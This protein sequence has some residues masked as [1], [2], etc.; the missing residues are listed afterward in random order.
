MSENARIVYIANC[1]EW[2]NQHGWEGQLE[3][4]VT[5]IMIAFGEDDDFKKHFKLE[6]TRGSN[7]ASMCGEVLDQIRDYCKKHNPPLRLLFC[8][9]NYD[10]LLKAKDGEQY[11]HR[12]IRQLVKTYSNYFF[13]ILATSRNQIIPDFI[14]MQLRVPTTFSKAE[15]VGVTKHFANPDIYTWIRES[16]HNRILFF[17]LVRRLTENNPREVILLLRHISHVDRKNNKYYADLLECA[18]E[19]QNSPI[20]IENENDNKDYV[21]CN[22]QNNTDELTTLTVNDQKLIT[23]CAFNRIYFNAASISNEKLKREPKLLFHPLITQ[24][25]LHGVD[26]NTHLLLRFN[27]PR[28]G[29]HAMKLVFGNQRNGIIEV[30]E[31]FG[32]GSQ[33]KYYM[34]YAGLNLLIKECELNKMNSNEFRFHST[35]MDMYMLNIKDMSGNQAIEEVAKSID[36]TISYSGIG[37]VAFYTFA[38]KDAEIGPFKG[39]DFALKYFRGENAMAYIICALYLSGSDVNNIID[40]IEKKFVNSDYI[41]TNKYCPVVDRILSGIDTIFKTHQELSG[42]NSKIIIRLVTSSAAANNQR[43]KDLKIIG[44]QLDFMPV[45]IDTTQPFANINITQFQ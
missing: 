36:D 20:T 30:S 19:F 22:A 16:K 2:A 11:A 37:S 1:E 23:F 42:N 28:T 12:Y 14:S 21:N 38:A 4:F 5:A 9:D 43:W 34:G 26:G 44:S 17:E 39:V 10:A 41:F 6:F 18:I 33:E 25:R 40:N 3:Y 45:S 29:I 35:Q 27:T 24:Q 31:F 7:E 15:I 13:L 8:L 32:N